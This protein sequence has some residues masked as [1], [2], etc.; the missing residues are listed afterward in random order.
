[1]LAISNNIKTYYRVLILV[2]YV[3]KRG[4]VSSYVG[5]RSVDYKLQMELFIFF[6]IPALRAPSTT[7]RLRR[8]ETPTNT[9]YA[10][11]EL[12]LKVL[13]H[14]PRFCIR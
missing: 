7:M 13:S 1:M 6:V 4:N 10:A 2:F 5:G 3:A 12:L 14:S 9:K 8:I 11:T